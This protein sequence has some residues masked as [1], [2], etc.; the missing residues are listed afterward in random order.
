MNPSRSTRSFRR[1]AGPL[2]AALLCAVVAMLLG[3]APAFAQEPLTVPLGDITPTLDG[4]CRSV[5]GA[6]EYADASSFDF[7]DVYT[8]TSKIYIKQSATDLWVCMEAKPG[9]FER[10]AASLYIDTDN[11]K[12]SV[13]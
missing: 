7:S 8:S 4:A 13:A 1:V 10:R 12:E 11:A 3:R 9:T 6:P 5:T 2:V